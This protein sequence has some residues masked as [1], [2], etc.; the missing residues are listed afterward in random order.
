MLYM[1]NRFEEIHIISKE[2]ELNG[3]FVTIKDHSVPNLFL[4][5]IK[6]RLLTSNIEIFKIVQKR[7]VKLVFTDGISHGT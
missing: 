7:N 5:R 3:K 2:N 4:H 1:A 6:G